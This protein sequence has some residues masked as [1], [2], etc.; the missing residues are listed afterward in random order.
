[1]IETELLAF[2]LEGKDK[3]IAEIKTF[4]GADNPQATTATD[5]RIE[6]INLPPGCLS[7]CSAGSEPYITY[8]RT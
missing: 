7:C 8:S 5:L 2:P 1:M 6:P 4:N 3:F